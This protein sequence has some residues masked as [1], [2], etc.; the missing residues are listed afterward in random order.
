M[1]LLPPTNS[2]SESGAPDSVGDTAD[3][4]QQDP[5]HLGDIYESIRGTELQARNVK[6]ISD[7]NVGKSSKV[8]EVCVSVCECV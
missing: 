1:I 2:V 4:Q 8:N 6:L 5:Q 3:E 7:Y